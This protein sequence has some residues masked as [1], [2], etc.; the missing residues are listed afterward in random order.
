MTDLPCPHSSTDEGLPLGRAA[1]AA[2]DPPRTPSG[3]SH[4]GAHHMPATVERLCRLP[5]REPALNPHL[6]RILRMR[7]VTPFLAALIAA[8]SITAPMS[9]MLTGAQEATPAMTHACVVGGARL[10]R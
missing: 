4:I 5:F 7:R 1:L 10:G 2:R 9:T 3:V 8:L 6:W